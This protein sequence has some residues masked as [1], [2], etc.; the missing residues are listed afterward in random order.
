MENQPT[1]SV[2]EA[3]AVINQTLEYAH[4]FIIVVGEVANYKISGGKWLFFDIKDEESSMKCFMPVW[5]LR[6]A[7]EDGMKIQVIAKPR[8]SKYG[9]SL[10]VEAIKPVGEGDIKRAFELLRAKLDAEG[11]FALERKRPLPV[12]PS[13]I[14]VV[15]STDAA[16]YKDFIKILSE[17]FGGLEIIVYNTA[18]QGDDAP[19]QIMRG[20]KYFNEM[21]LPPEVIAILRGGGSRD[22][23]VAFDDELLVRT[24]AGSRVPTI[25]GVGHEIDIT[26]ADLVADVRA[27]TPSNAAEILVPDKREI[28]SGLDA[29]LRHILLKTENNLTRLDEHITDSQGNILKILTYKVEEFEKHLKYL[30]Q[31]LRQLNPKVVLKRGYSIVRDGKGKVLKTRPR[32]GDKVDI[33]NQAVIFRAKVESIG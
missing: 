11:L 17:R 13:R 3:I 26:L 16:G 5:N 28:A 23:L 8:I 2:S 10:N 6:V 20:I 25:V 21:E 33:E 27:S 19:D 29:E 30:L 15:S 18:V 24:I 14:G 1:L 32:V 22:D 12:L 9:F 7:I 4:P 31:N